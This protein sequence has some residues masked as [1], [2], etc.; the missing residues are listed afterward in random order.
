[1]HRQFGQIILS[2]LLGVCAGN[3]LAGKPAAEPAA[4]ISQ[5]DCRWLAQHIPAKYV[6]YKPGIDVHGRPVTSADLPDQTRLQAPE[7]VTIEI[8]IPLR[9]LGRATRPGTDVRLEANLGSITVNT[10]TGEVRF[11]DQSLNPGERADVAKN[12]R[13]NTGGKR[14]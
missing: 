2:L 5:K 7:T 13:E 4:R 11:N 8:L 3:A 14:K 6:A 12:C 1:M 9:V 10:V